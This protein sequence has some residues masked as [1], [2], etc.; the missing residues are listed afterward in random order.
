MEC[1]RTVKLNLNELTKAVSAVAGIANEN[2]QLKQDMKEGQEAIDALTASLIAAA[3]SPAGAVGLAAVSA[4]LD[5]EAV[6]E[7]IAALAAK[8]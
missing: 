5:P 4:A 1:G 3:T 7:A 6:N 8:T 2:A